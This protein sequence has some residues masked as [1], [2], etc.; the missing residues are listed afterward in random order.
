[1]K[2]IVRIFIGHGIT[3]VIFVHFTCVFTLLKCSIET[4]K[5]RVRIENKLNLMVYMDVLSI[6]QK[7]WQP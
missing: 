6:R 5:I 1:M 2:F 4:G 7:H 3:L